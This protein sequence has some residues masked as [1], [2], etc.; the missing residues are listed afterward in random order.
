MGK[1]QPFRIMQTRFLSRAI[2]C[3]GIALY[4]G[5]VSLPAAANCIVGAGSTTCDRLS[6]NPY[7]IGIGIGDGRRTASPYQAIVQSGARIE[8]TGIGVT[9]S[10]A[11]SLHDNAALNFQSRTDVQTTTPFAGDEGLSRTGSN[12]LEFKNNSTVL[13][14]NKDVFIE[15]D[16]SAIAKGLNKSIIF[17]ETKASISAKGFNNNTVSVETEALV[18]AK[19]INNSTVSAKTEASLIAKGINNSAV[20]VE[21]FNRS[22]VVTFPGVIAGT[23]SVSQIGPGTTILIGDNT[24]T[25]GTRITAGTLQLGN[26]GMTGGIVGDVVDNGALAFNRSD[27]V[28]F[29][30]VIAGTGSVSQIGPGTTILTGDNTYTGGTNVAFGVLALGDPSHTGAAL[31]GG[32]AVAVSSGATFG[33][34]GSVT[35]IITN[36]GTITVGNALPTFV[37][38]PVGTLTIKGDLQNNA[39][40]R[41]ASTSTIGNVLAVRG[42][43]ASSGGRL[44]ISTLLNTG[45]SLSNQI[46]DRL[47]ITGNAAG[48]TPVQVNAT[49]AP[50]TVPDSFTPA[51]LRGISIVQVGG[52]SS[53]KTLQLTNDYLTGGGPFA[54][55]L[56]AFG[57][58]S[59]SGLTDPRQSLVGDSPNHWDYRLENPLVSNGASSRPEVAPQV[60]SFL[61][62]STALFN[63]GFQNL[64]SLHHRLGEI[65]DDQIQGRV[66]QGGVFIRTF[67]GRFNYTSNRGFSDY[68]FNSAQDYAATQFGGNRIALDTAAGTM[69]IGMAGTLGRLWYQPSAV[70]GQSKGL[71]NTETLAGTVT[72]Q[73]LGGWYVDAIVAGGLFD[74]RVITAARGQITGLNG[75][76]VAASIEGG[77]PF[78]VSGGFAL[79]PQLQ[80]VYQ[81]LNFSS[82]TDIDGIGVDLGSPNQGI[83]RGGARLTK[84]LETS[85]GTLVTPYL[86]ANVLQGVSG[87]EAVHL[88]SVS[89]GTGAYG[90]ALQ[91]GG[92]VTGTLTRNLSVHGDVAWQHDVGGAGS[93]GWAFNGGL[94]Y[95]FGVAPAPITAPPAPPPAFARDYLVFFDWDRADLTEETRQIVAEAASALTR[96]TLTQILVNGHTDKSGM[97]RYNQQLSM[98]RAKTIAA[99]LVRDGVPHDVISIRG[100]GQTQLLV[101]TGP[102]VREPRNR[103]VEIV[104]R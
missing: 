68:G 77:Y 46:T 5:V 98:R 56:L 16:G 83:F 86:K 15:T 53:P 65:R 73:A 40:V 100:L 14:N 9:D 63:A 104:I 37:G 13:I 78:P 24:Y 89:F 38:G 48:A 97:R 21:T 62:A 101:P 41:L 82:R 43:Y 96:V 26:G 67:G 71:F 19:R 29:P 44:V 79:E 52:A 87:G 10:N 90:T 66:Q 22:D 31:S 102:D 35:G 94:R 27:V 95:A 28:T 75:T 70:D 8:A 4:F 99:E 74:G 30:G 3:F 1:R 32:G 20:S 103:R 34:Y 51:N 2:R 11:I 6:P 23:G 18:I 12:T 69:R 88:S 33:G 36:N 76:S 92:G 39:V 7:G 81:H 54:Y 58:G 61:T 64:D 55:R 42:N 57:P 93:R 59:D 47:L 45:G 85:D 72:W 25:G 91:V 50:V 17:T 84:H 49:A 60:P 80:F